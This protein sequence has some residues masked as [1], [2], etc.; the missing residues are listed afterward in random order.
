MTSSVPCTRYQN[1]FDETLPFSNYN[2][3]ALLASG[4][5]LTYTVPGISTQKFRVRFA[6]SYTAE[7]WV[8]YN[9][10]ATDPSS[11]TATTNSFQELIPLKECRV[12]SGGST[13]SFLAPASTPRVSAALTLIEE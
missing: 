2:F 1:N 6:C 12:V 10:T 5:A 8:K 11:N 13:I 9:G 7:V 3:N 4:T